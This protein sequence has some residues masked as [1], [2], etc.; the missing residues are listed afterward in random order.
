MNANI[1]KAKA[2]TKVGLQKAQAVS[3]SALERATSAASGFD[4]K[5]LAWSGLALALVILLA[6]N[7]IAST[8]FRAAKL[9][10]TQD[11]L[12][13]ISEGTKKALRAIDELVAG[14]LGRRMLDAI[15]HRREIH[16]AVHDGVVVLEEVPESPDPA[17]QRPSA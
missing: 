11:G 6:V 16:A 1:D 15:D 17:T 5:T 8:Q 12:F 10:L 4:R 7:L 9:D 14:P 3:S 2:A 13:T